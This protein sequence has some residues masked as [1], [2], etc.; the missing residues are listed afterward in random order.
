MT[1]IC[2]PLYLVVLGKTPVTRGRS[3]SQALTSSSMLV[4]G[5][6]TQACRWAR[7]LVTTRNNSDP[8]TMT[9]TINL[10]PRRASGRRCIT[11][12]TDTAVTASMSSSHAAPGG[13]PWWLAHNSRWLEARSAKTCVQHTWLRVRSVV[14][15]P[16]AHRSDYDA[17][18]FCVPP[19]C[20][21]G[22]NS[23]TTGDVELLQS[24]APVLTALTD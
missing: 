1:L 11:C 20:N 16:H 19:S 8:G 3:S 5:D 4:Y 10:A 14:Y 15:F 13:T 2:A 7:N 22:Y 12:N 24:I 18:S 23:I 9:V 17:Y 6:H 21:T